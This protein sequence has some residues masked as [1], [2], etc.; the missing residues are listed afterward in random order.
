MENLINASVTKQF[1]V[2]FPGN[3]NDH[4]TLFGGLAMQWMD[5]TAYITAIR[6]AKK[7]MV[8]VSVDTIKFLMPVKPGSII[9]IIGKVIK[10]G[11]V[12]LKISVEM[13]MEDMFINERVKTV[14]AVFTFAAI[15]DKNKPIP[16]KFTERHQ[17]VIHN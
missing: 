7:K 9:E 2:I 10:P 6:F 17:T 15:N 4:E 13:F 12:K 1:R 8:T 5:E 11:S 3:L 16:L 14:E